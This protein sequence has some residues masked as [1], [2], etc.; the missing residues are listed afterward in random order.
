MKYYTSPVPRLTLTLSHI[1]LNEDM[2]SKLVSQLFD[3]WMYTA[4]DS[5]FNDVSN[6][7]V[8]CT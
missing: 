8:E 5:P 7:D 3:Q 2:C 4:P 1:V 6:E